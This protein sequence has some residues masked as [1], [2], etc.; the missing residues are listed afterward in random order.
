MNK[1]YIKIRCWRI[2]TLDPNFTQFN[3]VVTFSSISFMFFFFVEGLVFQ[4]TLSLK[5]E[6]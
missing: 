1:N 4:K 2:E 6:K 3:S 5:L